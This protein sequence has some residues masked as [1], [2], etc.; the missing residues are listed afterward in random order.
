[1][2][3]WSSKEIFGLLSSEIVTGENYIKNNHLVSPK[4]VPK[5]YSKWIYIYFKNLNLVSTV[6]VS[7]T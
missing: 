4:V 3:K 5:M 1:M 7:S 2:W 6:S